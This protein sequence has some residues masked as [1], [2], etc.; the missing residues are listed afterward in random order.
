MR[1]RIVSLIAPALA[2]LVSGV[3]PAANAENQPQGAEAPTLEQR[4]RVFSI[5]ERLLRGMAPQQA[6]DVAVLVREKGVRRMIG[7]GTEQEL[8]E[9]VR[10]AAL[11]AGLE[12]KYQPILRTDTAEGEPRR[13][14]RDRLS[15][16]VEELRAPGTGVTYLFSPMGWNLVGVLDFAYGLKAKSLTYADAWMAVLDRGFEAAKNPG[17]VEDMKLLASG[18]DRLPE[19]TIM[20][21]DE[22]ELLG[23]G[24]R[25]TIPGSIRLH[26]KQFGEGPAVY[27][28]HGGPGESHLVMRPYLDALSEGHTLVYF[29]QRGC[30]YSDKPQFREAYGIDRLVEDLEHLRNAL[31]HDKISLLAQSSGGAV[32]VR[33]ALAHRDRVEKLIIVSSWASAEE[34]RS[35]AMIAPRLIGAEDEKALREI[36]E[37]LTAQHRGYND[38]ELSTMQ[39][40]VY[41]SQ[42]FGRL[43]P[44]FRTDWARRCRLSALTFDALRGEY[45]GGPGQQNEMDLRPQLKSLEGIPTLVVCGEFD[46]VTPPQIM[47]TFA[48]GIPGARFEIIENS[49]H[50]P[51]AEQNAAF[52]ERVRGFLAEK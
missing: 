46:V 24:K 23:R 17:F 18:L 27:L 21:L 52:I 20:P 12:M 14:D 16:L 25:I 10:Q 50:Y 32:A 26:V 33:Y 15:S 40:L 45:M 22:K 37:T 35:V 11:A 30:G 19:P 1:F 2:L 48:E 3:G 49:G 28:L 44:E 9:D 47:R 51:F 6:G 38:E 39:K 42:F 43:T 31:G 29:D 41:P 4:L 13:V 8:A 36:I 7:L 5:D 34:F